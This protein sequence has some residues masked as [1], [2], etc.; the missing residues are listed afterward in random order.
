MNTALPPAVTCRRVVPKRIDELLALE[1]CFATDRAS[2]RN[3][4]RLLRSP[5]ACCIGAYAAGQLVGSMVVLFRRN[6]ATARIYSLA[7]A[8][9]ARGRGI[10]RRMLLRAESEARRRGCRRLRLEV[11]MD[12]TPAIRLYESLG[13]IDSQ[14]LP[15]YYEDGAHGMLY[16]KEL[17]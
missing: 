8:T 2:R 10:A 1:E 3:L 17:M 9:Q 11:R 7:V 4:L 15:G 16:R 5:S 6:S 12:N 13:F 14:V